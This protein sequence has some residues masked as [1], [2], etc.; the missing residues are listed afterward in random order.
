MIWHVISFNVEGYGGRGPE[1]MADAVVQWWRLLR[2]NVP[3]CRGVRLF[4]HVA[5]LNRW[6]YQVWLAYDG[7]DGWEAAGGFMG[8]FPW[9]TPDPRYPPIRR[10]VV[11]T[12]HQ[13]EM[14][15]EI[16]LE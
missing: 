5:G 2:D 1:E 15:E 14:L 6:H 10:L 13:D 11:Q 7:I 3:G 12:E 4:R 16:P 8:H 9:S